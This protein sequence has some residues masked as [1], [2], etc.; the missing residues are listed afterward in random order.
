MRKITLLLLALLAAC[1]PSIGVEP[2]EDVAIPAFDVSAATFTAEIARI[3]PSDYGMSLDKRTNPLYLVDRENVYTYDN[4]TLTI[5]NYETGLV[6][7]FDLGIRGWPIHT[8]AE[9][10]LHVLS[11]VGTVTF[12]I[13]GG[14]P[15]PMAVESFNEPIDAEAVLD[16]AINDEGIVV[17]SPWRQDYVTARHGWAVRGGGQGL[18]SFTI[19]KDGEITVHT[20]WPVEHLMIDADGR[21]WA[22]LDA[23]TTG[24]RDIGMR[25]DGLNAYSVYDS[26]G[27]FLFNFEAGFLWDASG[28]RALVTG[29]YFGEYVV[30]EF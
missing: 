18:S 1:E 15:V 10:R 14:S 19:L 26:S 8:F 6:R 22:R 20:G 2:S 24:D 28:D 12:G 11:R 5:A 23:L 16:M 17:S 27:R 29:S 30:M 7:T 13:D 3:S 4:P 9:G 25:S 21:I